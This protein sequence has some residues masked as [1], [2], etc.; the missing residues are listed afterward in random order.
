MIYFSHARILEKCLQDN[1]L[2]GN[3]FENACRSCGRTV[4]DDHKRESIADV[5]L[6]LS[7]RNAEAEHLSKNC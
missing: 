6:T 2:S 1:R 5:I 4:F 7:K 3:L